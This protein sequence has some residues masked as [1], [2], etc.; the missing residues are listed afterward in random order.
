MKLMYLIMILFLLCSVGA[1]Q[2]AADKERFDVVLHPGDV[3]EKTLKVT[4]VG[5]APIVKISSTQVS[6]SAKK[7][8]LLNIPKVKGLQPRGNTEIKIYFFVPT[9]TKPG[10]YT[11]YIYLL[12]SAPP[13]LPIRIEFNINVVGRE[14]YGLSI[15]IND[16]VTA[17]TYA[18]PKGL[19][20]FDLAVKNLGTFRDIA[21]IDTSPLPNG[22]TVSIKD[23]EKEFPLPYDIPL[24]PGTTHP[25][26]LLIESSEPGEKGQINIVATS[27]GNSSRNA[28]VQANVEVGIVFRGYTVDIKV[29]EMMVSNKTYRGSLS[30]MLDVKERI[31]VTI[32]APPELMV[33]PLAMVMEVAPDKKGTATFT[34]LA[35]RPGEYPLVF[36]LIDSHGIPLPKEMVNVNVVQPVG[37]AVL[38]GDEFLHGTVASLA[39]LENRSISVITVP[40][41]KLREDD[42]ER[43]QNFARVV[44]LGNESVVS[45]DAEK[46]ME[47]TEIRRIQG[48]N[49]CEETWL[50]T[51]EIWQ[52]GTT[53]VVL[54]SSRP[55][56]IFKAYLVANMNGLP[57]VVCEG[58]LTDAARSVIKEMTRRNIPLSKALTV[59]EIGEEATTAMQDAGVL[60]EEVRP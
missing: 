41:G 37:L 25:M 24:N 4:N 43:L 38:T 40:P 21:S 44:I 60:T 10:S 12:N 28:S 26:K 16:A 13:S 17:S 5:D 18:K 34:M 54:S 20:Q 58:N 30:L 50:F 19:A 14:N 46:T 51:A 55:I 3:L 22:W 36:K 56:D 53:E 7:F 2:L 1:A 42:R 49:L 27:L 52:N 45:P 23:G 11:G 33:I 59:G 6:G 47:G 48:E 15:T 35:S 8:I 39:D 9:E 57:L 29:P 31:P 32:V